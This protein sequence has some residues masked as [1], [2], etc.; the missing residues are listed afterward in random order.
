MVL[1]IVKGRF[2]SQLFSVIRNQD[3][4]NP[5]WYVDEDGNDGIAFASD[6][7][8]Y[9]IIFDHFWDEPTPLFLLRSYPGLL[10]LL[11]SYA[12]LEKILYK[13]RN[14]FSVFLPQEIDTYVNPNIPYDLSF[15]PFPG[16]SYSGPSCPTVSAP[17]YTCARAKP[18]WRPCP[19]LWSCETWSRRCVR[20]MRRAVTCPYP[21]IQIV[22]AWLHMKYG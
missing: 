1:Q 14:T 22:I 13:V 19:K 6:F 12:H 20:C 10:H 4:Y 11:L 5:M 8:S 16:P 15:S 21:G 17:V 9:Q 7:R 2:S 3:N 18:F